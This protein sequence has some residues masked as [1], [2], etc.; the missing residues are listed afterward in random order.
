MFCNDC[1]P[2]HVIQ[3]VPLENGCEKM[4]HAEKE[5]KAL[6]ICTVGF[7]TIACKS[8]SEIFVVVVF[9][10]GGGGIITDFCLE[11]CSI[12]KGKPLFLFRMEL[13]FHLVISQF[14]STTT[15]HCK[16]VDWG[17]SAVILLLVTYS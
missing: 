8:G 6:G 14:S 16:F 13:P 7:V 17:V 12:T 2:T 11:F 10:K 3:H 4:L 9:F 1:T 15:W 5:E